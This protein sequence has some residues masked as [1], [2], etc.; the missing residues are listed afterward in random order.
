MGYEWAAEI[1]ISISNSTTYQQYISE[2]TPKSSKLLD[3]LSIETYGDLGIS[4]FKTPT[5]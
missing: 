4:N 2:G 3:H 5:K 1:E